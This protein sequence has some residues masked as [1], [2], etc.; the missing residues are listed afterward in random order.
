MVISRILSITLLSVINIIVAAHEITIMTDPAGVIINN[1]SGY[2]V[3]LDNFHGAL[4]SLQ[5]PI[6][7]PHRKSSDVLY[8]SQCRASTNKGA[9]NYSVAPDT[10]KRSGVPVKVITIYN[11]EFPYCRH[12]DEEG[13]YYYAARSDIDKANRSQ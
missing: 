6:V 5:N 9:I 7:L 1:E 10:W 4:N 13:D 3:T 2:T 11:S 12:Y 8:I